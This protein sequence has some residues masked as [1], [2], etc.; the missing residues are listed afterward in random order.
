[1]IAGSGPVAPPPTPHGIVFLDSLLKL[2]L[3]VSIPCYGPPPETLASGGVLER[4]LLTQV[5]AFLM[6]ALLERVS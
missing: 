4:V 6:E 1:M 2:M 5:D 3:S